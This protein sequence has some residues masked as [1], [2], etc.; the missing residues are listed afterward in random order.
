M[1]PRWLTESVIPAQLVIWI[2]LPGSILGQNNQNKTGNPQDSFDPLSLSTSLL[3]LI[4]T[5][6]RY[7]SICCLP[8]ALPLLYPFSWKHTNN[9]PN[10]ILLLTH[11]SYCYVTP[12]S[13]QLPIHTC[14]CCCWPAWWKRS[15]LYRQLGIFTLLTISS[16]SSSSS[17]CN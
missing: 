7:S 9:G 11:A 2:C 1:Y 13:S 12:S 17:S 15:L 16:T 10:S 4:S 5:L 6:Y 8:P 14:F 3:S